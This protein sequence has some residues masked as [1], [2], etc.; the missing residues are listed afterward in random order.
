MQVRHPGWCS[1]QYQNWIDFGL[2]LEHP[3]VDPTTQI[4]AGNDGFGTCRGDRGTPLVCAR[5]GRPVIMGID[6][7][8]NMCRRTE[9]YPGI[10]TKGL[11]S[12]S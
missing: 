5:E 12:F 6:S 7:W 10:F 3:K 9:F 2:P 4:C 11:A 8:G 1:A